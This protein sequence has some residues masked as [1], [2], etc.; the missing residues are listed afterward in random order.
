[1]KYT[2]EDKTLALAG[3][4]QAC[5]LVF[6]IAHKG[7]CNSSAFVSI[8]ETLFKIDSHNVMDIFG[9]PVELR[10]GLNTL[11]K[12]LSGDSNK[13]ELEITRYLI[14][15]LHLQKK[16][17]KNKPMQDLISERLKKTQDQM[18]YFDLNHENIIAS[19]GS[20]YQDSISNLQPR[21]LVHG[22]QIYLSQASNSNKIRALLLAGIRCAVLWRQLGGNRFELLFMRKKLINCADILLRKL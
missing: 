15:L 16:L 9:S 13:A 5:Q 19:I 11:K 18:D 17:N 2:I 10:T 20:I 3:I 4:F 7:Q 21:I 22:E 14:S 1:M 8:L 6:D 12:Q